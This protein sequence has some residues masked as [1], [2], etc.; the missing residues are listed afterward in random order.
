MGKIAELVQKHSNYRKETLNLTSSE[1]M[2][3]PS[4][5]QLLCPDLVHRYVNPKKFTAEPNIAT[6]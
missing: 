5:R 3:T 1:N 6:Q 4:S 2:M